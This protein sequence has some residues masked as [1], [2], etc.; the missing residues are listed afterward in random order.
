VG[1]DNRA[2]PLPFHALIPLTAAVANVLICALVLRDGMRDRLHR[3]FAALTLASA[4]WDLGIF[5]LYYF[6]DPVSAEWWSRM[7]RTGICLAPPIVVHFGLVLSGERTS[8][9]WRRVLTVGY[10]L[11]SL[12]ALANFAGAL[13]KGVSPHTWGWYVEPTRL[14]TVLTVLLVASL[15][16]WVERV[17]N[18]Y[19]HSSSPRQRAQAKFWL[20]AIL[21]QAPFVIT[22]LLPIYGIQIYPLGNLGN[23]VFVAVVAY[24]IVRHRLM[25]VDYVVRKGLSFLLAAGAVLLPGSVAL[26]G[27]GRAIGSEEPIIWTCAATALALTAVVLVPTLQ[28][29]IETH[30][31]RALF[32]Q[33][34][35]Y[36]L[37]LRQL[38]AALVHVLDQGE[39]VQRLGDS[40]TE[41]LDT[42]GCQLLLR[43]E[44]NRR[45]TVLYPASGSGEPLSDE[46]GRRLDLLDGPV[47][48]SELEARRSPLAPLFHAR[49]WE[50]GIPLRINERPLGFIGL[51]KNRELRLFSGEDLQLLASVAA[52]AT[53]ALENTSLSRQLHR[54]EQVLERANRLSSLG[55]LAAGIAHEIRNPLVAV[56]TFLDLIPQRLDDREFLTRFR[57][58]SL[59]ELRRVTDLIADLLTLG[60]SKTA[61]RRAVDLESAL[62]P[63]VRLMESTSRKREVEL[64]AHFALGLP[65]AW[66]DEDQVKQ[67][68]LNL[69]LNAIEAS[70]AGGRVELDVRPAAAG[71]VA[72]EVRDQGAGMSPEELENI[73]HPFF[74]TKESGTG[75]GLALTHQMVVEHGGEISVQS[76]VGSGT[77]F[78]VILPTV[79][80]P[81]PCLGAET[82]PSESPAALDERRA[83]AG[84]A[85]AAD[86]SEPQLVRAR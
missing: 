22:N 84:E 69:I 67:I 7:F 46:M 12:L 26:L 10:L 40:L 43:D 41:V 30:V 16:L 51:G 29:A 4:S 74:T 18:I 70:P 64:K 21:L 31:H 58:L 13:V 17:L 75:L 53:V 23:V 61:A 9:G 68:L 8:R 2:K 52:G 25:D 48:A 73:F 20:F 54:S 36:Q 50:V 79:V 27:L 1:A 33:R 49:G 45:L 71:Q 78:R 42:E 85:G 57:E 63:V 81:R 62:E 65:T 32:P 34:Y 39:L 37:R 66:A 3:L 82:A 24:A 80:A 77:T 72:L 15:V 6:R 83:A 38:A 11:G 35:D 55:M 60:K 76:K 19:R 5:S 47:L 86:F 14:Y 56:K 59:A 44:Q 28:H